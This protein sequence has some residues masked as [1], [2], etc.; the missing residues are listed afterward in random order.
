MNPIHWLSWEFFGKIGA[1]GNDTHQRQHLGDMDDRVTLRNS[2]RGEWET[3]FFS[4]VAAQLGFHF[5]RYFTVRVGYQMMFFS[6]L[7]LAPDQISK[8]VGRHAGRE[9]HTH[10]NAIVHGVFGGLVIGFY[11]HEKAGDDSQHSTASLRLP[12][13]GSDLVR[14]V[15]FYK[16]PGKVGML[17][18]FAFARNP[19]CPLY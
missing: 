19:N 8:K 5:L 1:A 3:L 9:D 11:R 13:S 16:V 4:D 10:G 17:S 2:E 12:P 6:G 15:P 18:F 14:I 7:S